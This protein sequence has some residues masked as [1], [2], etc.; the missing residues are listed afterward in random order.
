MTKA[1]SK[2]KAPE[3]IMRKIKDL[4]P[5]EYN[6]RTMTKE[7]YRHIKASLDRFDCVV[8]V[9]VNMHK[10]RTN[11]IVGGHQRV[12]ILDDMGETEVPTVE[13][14]L[15]LEKEKE[16]NVRLNRNSADWD[17]DALEE[18]FETSELLDWGF[19]DFELVFEKEAGEA[20][21]VEEDDFDAEPPEEPK[22]E[23]GR[24]YQLG[25]HRLLCG[26]S[27]N[28]KDVKRLMD[29]ELADMIHTDPPYNIA[30]EGGTKKRE[31]IEND[32]M[33]E[34]FP[35]FLKAF[36][37]CAFDVLKEGGAIYVWHASTETHNFIVQYL[38]A[39]FLFKSYIVWNKNNSTFGRSD[40]HWK[41]EPCIYGWKPGAGH[42]WYGD[43]KQTTVWDVERPNRSDEHPTM[44]PL[45]LCA[46]AIQNS[47][48]KEE[49]VLDLFGGSGSTLIACEETG[50]QARLME[51][52]PKYC[53]VIV[54][55]YCKLKGLDPEKVFETGVAE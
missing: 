3:I 4:I 41:H 34:D 16:L 28:E 38:E 50:R 22:T 8:P 51:F 29:G 17:F 33:G 13:V 54:K 37:D 27:T 2:K 53:D 42:N 49:V 25:T 43:R 35:A 21:D 12:K 10:D 15:P 39:G 6:P 46:T 40:Y 47:S 36:Y 9:V 18:Y 44:K 30:Y 20:E 23:P 5:A 1:Q 7:Q 11:I 45:K 52:D 31:M 14:W 32:S 24:M 48:T 26:D 55:R 19:E